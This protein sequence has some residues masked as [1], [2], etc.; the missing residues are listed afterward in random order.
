M[1]NRV[2]LAAFCVS[3]ILTLA[4]A[5]LADLKLV[6]KVHGGPSEARIVGMIHADP[7]IEVFV[8]KK[9]AANRTHD[10]GDLAYDVT[11]S[12][13]RTP[14]REELERLE[15]TLLPKDLTNDPIGYGTVYSSVKWKDLGKNPWSVKLKWRQIQL[16][17]NFKP[18]E[19]LMCL[20]SGDGGFTKTSTQSADDR[21]ILILTWE[22]TDA[23][24]TIK[25]INQDDY[26]KAMKDQETPH[27]NIWK[28]N[29]HGNLVATG[30]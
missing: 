12:F 16:P 10:R 5:C 20:L 3:G 23:D 24:S 6:L 18:R 2:K 8:D 22:G 4:P 21:G 28:L 11:V 7:P 13:S 17:V 15:L 29:R 1:T 19:R 25:V 27:W 14:N 26:I 30:K 9:L